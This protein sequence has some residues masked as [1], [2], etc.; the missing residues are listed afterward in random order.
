M[1]ASASSSARCFAATCSAASGVLQRAAAAHA[2]MRAARRDARRRSARSI[3][4]RRARCRSSACARRIA[5]LDALARQRAFDEHDLAVDVRD[6]A[7]FLVQRFD[8]DGIGHGLDGR[9]GKSA[10]STGARSRRVAR[11]RG[12]VK[13]RRCESSRSIRRPMAVG[14]ARATARAGSSAA[15]ARRQR[16]LASGCCRS[17][18]ELLARSRHDAR[19]ARRHRVRRGPGRVHRRAHRLRRRAGPGVRRR[20]CRCSAFRR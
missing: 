8:R 17:S 15:R 12:A 20:I 5:M 3:A 16:A 11:P 14:R 2:E 7:A 13:S 1:R 9:R 6:A 10:H 18:R 19:A 4:D